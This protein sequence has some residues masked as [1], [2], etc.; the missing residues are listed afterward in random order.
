MTL[1]IDPNC[2]YALAL[3]GGG[4]RGAWQIGA[5][6]ALREAGISINAASGS[7]V[8]A[9]NGALIAMGDLEKAE[10]IWE[11]I[12][13][14]QVIDADPEDLEKMFSEPLSAATIAGAAR[15]LFDMILNR[16]LDV[17]PLR[18]W[19]REAVDEDAVRS[20]PIELFI[21][22]FSITD[23][24][25]LELRAK[26][27]TEKGDLWDMLLA[28][29]YFPAFRGEDLGGKR[30][31]DGGV[32]DVL[33][34][35][36]L[37]ENGYKNI[38]ALRLHGAGIERPVRIPR[39]TQVYHVEPS[40]DL[41]GM[42]EFDAE[43]SRANLR[44]GYY[45]TKRF[46]YGL[47]GDKWYID[48]Q[49]DEEPARALLADAALRS[50]AAATA[51]EAHEQVLPALG[52]K[53]DKED[54]D[55]RDLLCACLEWAAEKADVDRWKIYDEDELL[56]AAGGKEALQ[57][58]MESVAEPKQTISGVPE[59]G[60]EEQ[61]KKDGQLRICLMNDSFPPVVDGVANVVLNYAKILTERGHLC[62]V[63]TPEYPGVK[64]DYPFPV[65]RYPSLNTTRLAGYRAGSPDVATVK[66]LAALEPDVLHCHCPVASA[67]LARAVRGEVDAPLIFT[68]HTKFDID[69][70]GTIPTP[71]LQDAAIRLLVN[72]ISACD[73]VW[74]VSEGAGENLRSLG[75][76]GDYIVMPNGVDLPRGLAP[77]EA[78]DRLSE[79]WDLPEDVPVYL[80]LGR[81]MWYKGLRLILDALAKVR[82]AGRDFRM[83]FVGDGRDRAAVMETAKELGLDDVCRFPGAERDRE[84]IRAWYTRADLF[85]FPSTFDTN[86]LVVREAA[87][88]SLGSL[89]IRGSCAAE[90][91]VHGETGLLAAE[92]A[93]DIAAMLL[94]PLA[95]R[96]ALR[97]LGSRAAERIYLSWEDSVSLA[98]EQYRKVRERWDRG[99]MHR[100]R[101]RFDSL[102]EIPGELSAALTRAKEIFE[103]TL[104]T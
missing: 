86:G 84:V 18:N 89:L 8:G 10:K 83:V 47:K 56:S 102:F 53:L 63:A 41:G 28:S 49:W 50:G 25:E 48:P 33:P 51:R 75:Y 23:R 94:S 90:G 59:A 20:S 14:S 34:L 101:V 32:R 97:G 93:D 39:G 68:Y 73:E 54:G 1:T 85:L 15:T 62:T 78:V 60:T 31:T 40:I 24:K 38:I 43:R 74:A 44:A 5:W 61:E 19:I 11:N 17:T 104:W 88:C 65:V 81:M 3:E 2:T 92:N 30:Y 96:A 35:H 52:R 72:N 67:V 98:E 29:A 26:D 91:I 4:A 99:E 37:I 100:K 64:D 58:L 87:A 45:D 6:K 57:P 36:A 46:L 66:A 42:L 13:Y 22:T 76:E 79:A 55:Y 7:S 9:L 16:G 70:A 21:N 95:E 77:R 71:A 80:F 12:N 69:I 103:R 27:L 82:A